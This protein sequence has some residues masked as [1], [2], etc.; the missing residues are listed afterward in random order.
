MNK[1]ILGGRFVPAHY[2]FTDQGSL[3]D[4]DLTTCWAVDR[5][6][7]DY[8]WWRIGSRATRGYGV[9]L[10]EHELVI[11]PH[12]DYRGDPIAGLARYEVRWGRSGGGGLPG[13]WRHHIAQAMWAAIPYPGYISLSGFYGPY[14]DHRIPPE[15]MLQACVIPECVIQT[16]IGPEIWDD[17]GSGAD[18][19]GSIWAINDE[20]GGPWWYWVPMTG[21]NPPQSAYRLNPDV[22]EMI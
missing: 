12:P 13:N 10:P 9:P 18:A 5:L 11:C 2:S 15:S 4:K 14:N 7:T 19:D 22:I 21:Y 8:A 1:F 17:R 20:S 6:P 3:A 16:E